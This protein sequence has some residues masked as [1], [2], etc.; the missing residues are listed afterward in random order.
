METFVDNEQNVF[1]AACGNPVSI[2]EIIAD[3][4]SHCAS[5]ETKSKKFREEPLTK[6]LHFAVISAE[7][8]IQNN[9][10]GVKRVP[11]F[12]FKYVDAHMCYLMN[13]FDNYETKREWNK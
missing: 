3:T 1:C 11:E 8:F 2:N 12:I 4:C 7:M 5:V 6:S 13:Y 10:P 9:Y